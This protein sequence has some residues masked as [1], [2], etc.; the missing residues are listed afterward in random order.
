MSKEE[1]E[2]IK[3]NLAQ[4]L[5]LARAGYPVSPEL[6]NP[7]QEMRIP[8]QFAHGP[9]RPVMR[10]GQV[11]LEQEL[12]IPPEMEANIIRELSQLVVNG[13]PQGEEKARK[14]YPQVKKR[15]LAAMGLLSQMVPVEG[16]PE[17]TIGMTGSVNL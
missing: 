6:L 16:V 2:H 11:F 10:D 13:E 3:R 9:T 14:A 4:N 7:T 1:D 8:M 5:M 17:G 12:E 15:I